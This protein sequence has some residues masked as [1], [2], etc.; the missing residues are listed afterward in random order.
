M[1]KL[2]IIGSGSQARYVIENIR[3]SDNYHL[4]GLVDIEKRENV[5][6]VVNGAKII[7][8]LDDIDK[9][10]SPSEV[11]LVIA[12]G[13]NQ[14]K[15]EIALS[16]EKSNYRFA[17]IV[18]KTAYI[19]SNVE[20]GKDCIINANVTIMPNTKIGDHVI[21][22]SGCVIEHDNIIDDFANIAPGVIT[23]GNV[24][25]GKG[26]YIYTGTSI[27]PKT[28]I[29]NWAVVGAGSVV[30]KNVADNDVVAGVPAVSIKQ[31]ESKK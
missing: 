26:S 28:K 8:I 16:L 10:F 31:N 21:I 18:N 27:I 25:I 9:Y 14:K 6:N 24:K 2:C 30:L 17:T 3:H 19:S 11:Y 23:A 1:M 5:G 22:H 4:E 7:C 29:G 20:I 12:Y 13:N 15:Q